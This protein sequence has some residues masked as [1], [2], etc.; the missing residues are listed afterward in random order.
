MGKL[1][2][3]NNEQVINA[4]EKAFAE[5]SPNAF[6]EALSENVILEAAVLYCPILGREK[7]K[8]VMSAASNIYDSVTFTNYAYT[9]FKQYI[10]WEAKAFGDVMLAGITI[11][12]RNHDNSISHIAINHRPLGNGLRFSAVLGERLRGEIDSI[13]F[14][15]ILEQ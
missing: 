6:A 1:T 14:Y 13:H 4:W 10:E 5:K 15:Q 3:K 8:K 9:D 2:N 12:T 11:L 7:V